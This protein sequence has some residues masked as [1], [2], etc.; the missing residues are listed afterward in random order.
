[1]FVPF[2]LTHGGAGDVKLAAALG[3]LLG[4]QLGVMA[5]V[6]TFLVAGISLLG[7]TIIR[8]GPIKLG[9]TCFQRAGSCLLP[10]WIA[11]PVAE[12]C[13]I[14]ARPVPMAGFFA[15]GTVW[16]CVEASWR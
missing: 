1:M 15:M 16:A 6:Y 9:R 8:M 5:L 10:L 13:R 14:L 4:V 7:W 3:S 2:C 12:Q 11:P